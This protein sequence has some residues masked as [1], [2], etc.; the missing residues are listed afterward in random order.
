M[1]QKRQINVR[2]SDA[3]YGCVVVRARLLE[4]S[5]GH[6]LAL[7]AQFWFAQGQPAVTEREALVR[8]KSSLS[9]AKPQ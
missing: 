3:I 5:H 8:V 2:V 7:I 1:P 6:Y 9:A 4:E